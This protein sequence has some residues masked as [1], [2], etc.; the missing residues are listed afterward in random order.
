MLTARRSSALAHPILTPPHLS[1]CPFLPHL[2]AFCLKAVG[3]QAI[4]LSSAA[5]STFIPEHITGI[6]LPVCPRAFQS[7]LQASQG[8][9]PSAS[10]LCPAPPWKIRSLSLLPRKDPY[11]LARC[12]KGGRI[13]FLSHSLPHTPHLCLAAHHSC[14]ASLAPSRARRAAPAWAAAWRNAGRLHC[15]LPSL[16]HPLTPNSTN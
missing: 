8:Y 9:S 15:P 5:V 16:T 13:P 2:R 3:F 7:C 1:L 11:R 14:P 6:A 4:S 10:S 12:S